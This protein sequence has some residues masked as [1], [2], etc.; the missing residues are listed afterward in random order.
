M[1]QDMVQ[2]GAKAIDCLLVPLRVFEALGHRDAERARMVRSLRKQRP[3]HARFRT[4]R[5]VNCGPVEL[6]ELSPLD[7]PIMY[8]SNPVDR[9]LKFREARRVG[10]GGPPLP[11]TGLGRQPLVPL[12][13]RVPSLGESRVHFVAARRAV[14]LRLVVELRR[15]PEP[16]L[17][18][19]SPDQ[20]S[21]PTCLAVQLLHLRRNLDPSLGGIL[22]PQ[23][24]GEVEYGQRLQARRTG[25]RILWRRQRFWEVRLDVV[26]LRRPFVV[27]KLYDGGVGLRHHSTK[28]RPT[29]DMAGPG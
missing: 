16:P 28:T 17:E 13:F 19:V 4:R 25:Y 29:S 15:R 27:R 5:R 11:C 7:L 12:L 26:P 21:R 24:L 1:E 6:H 20:R 23:A 9:R 2:D 10:E 14:E 18:A 3:A 22:L 8:G